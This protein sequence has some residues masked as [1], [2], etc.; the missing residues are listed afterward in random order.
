MM[1]S[2]KA[3][4]RAGANRRASKSCF[5][6]VHVRGFMSSLLFVFQVRISHYVGSNKE[7]LGIQDSYRRFP[8]SQ[9]Q[10][11]ERKRWSSFLPIGDSRSY[12]YHRSMVQ[13]DK[14]ALKI[15]L[16]VRSERFGSFPYY[17]TTALPCFVSTLFLWCE[18]I[19]LYFSTC[20]ILFSFL[21]AV[22]NPS[23]PKAFRFFFQCFC[24]TEA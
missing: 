18:M 17:L 23:F 14:D 15:W 22:L 21:T 19:R 1:G 6:V 3:E 11:L 4:W 13:I 7:I 5:W 16:K 8:N 10:V 9:V 12:I 2:M 20:Q 24:F